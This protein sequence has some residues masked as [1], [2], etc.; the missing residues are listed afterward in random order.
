MTKLTNIWN[1]FIQSPLW[2]KVV[3]VTALSIGIIWEFAQM[4]STGSTTNNVFL[5][6]IR[7]AGSMQNLDSAVERFM[8]SEGYELVMN[9][10]LRTFVNSE[11][12]TLTD[13]E[14]IVWFTED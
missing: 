2:M 5:K 4:F 9:G 14:A 11:G 12:K 7:K 8:R 6:A 10:K 1:V 13:G 3:I